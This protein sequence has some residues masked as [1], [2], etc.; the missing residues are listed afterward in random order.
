MDSF[1]QQSVVQIDYSQCVDEEIGSE[2]SKSLAK[3]HS[4][5][6]VESGFESDYF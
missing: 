1:L 5:Q 2:R 4:S 3:S 6:V